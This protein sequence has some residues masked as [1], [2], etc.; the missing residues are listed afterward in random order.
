VTAWDFPAVIIAA[1]AVAL[2][3]SYW[4]MRFSAERR[5]PAFSC[6]VCG[7]KQEG[8]LAREWRYCPYCGAPRGARSTADL[9]RRSTRHEP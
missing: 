4:L 2:G 9:P 7:R 8:L 3:V 1:V 6:E 5:L